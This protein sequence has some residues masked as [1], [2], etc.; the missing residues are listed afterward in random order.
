MP[1][2]YLLSPPCP[3][4]MLVCPHV[5][6][7]VGNCPEPVRPGSPRCPQASCPHAG[8][9]GHGLPAGI[10]GF[11][12][13]VICLPLGSVYPPLAPTRGAALGLA[14]VP[15]TP[16]C[17]EPAHP[18]ERVGAPRPGPFQPRLR[19]GATCSGRRPRSPGVDA[20]RRGLVL[21]VILYFWRRLPPTRF[22]TPLTFKVAK[23]GHL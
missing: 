16:S 19:H 12:W 7:L 18:R 11:V 9:L 2:N 15:S 13:R 14:A 6:G 20:G 23:S 1:R 22:L 8:V 17:E 21:I 4:L 10:W 5:L 3:R